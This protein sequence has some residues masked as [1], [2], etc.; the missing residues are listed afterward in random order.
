MDTPPDLRENP[1][2]KVVA[3]IKAFHFWNYGMDD[4]DPN[5]KFAEWVPDLA[6]AIV[7]ALS[8]DLG[9]AA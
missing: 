6:D 3:A 4:V 8:A 7:A 5:H 9:P 2:E 1:K